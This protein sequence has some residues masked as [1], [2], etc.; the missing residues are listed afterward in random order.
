MLPAQLMHTLPGRLYLISH[1]PLDAPHKPRFFGYQGGESHGPALFGFTKKGH[2]ELVKDLVETK[3]VDV[4]MRPGFQFKVETVDGTG[5]GYA[6]VV[7]E[8]YTV[9]EAVEIGGATGPP[10][11]VITEFD[12]MHLVLDAVGLI[13]Q[14]CETGM[15]RKELDQLVR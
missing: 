12:R 14:K 5:T 8:D 3:R 13:R 15:A 10:I 2:A 7:V 6:P 11:C 9:V 4:A 1:R